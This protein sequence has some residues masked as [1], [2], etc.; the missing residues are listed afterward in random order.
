[1]PSPVHHLIYHRHVKIRKK[2]ERRREKGGKVR[3]KTLDVLLAGVHSEVQ[4]P[5]GAVQIVSQRPLEL[6]SLAGALQDKKR[7]EGQIRTSIELA[8]TTAVANLL[9]QTAI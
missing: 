7:I 9:R 1:M 8:A 2:R 6:A 4:L 3:R 5:I